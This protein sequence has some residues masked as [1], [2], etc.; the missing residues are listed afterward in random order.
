[1]KLN[2]NNTQVVLY[3]YGS[4]SLSNLLKYSNCNVYLEKNK[5]NNNNNKYIRSNKFN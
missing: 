2:S 1:M 3:I 4:L 5:I